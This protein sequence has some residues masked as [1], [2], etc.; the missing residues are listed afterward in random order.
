MYLIKIHFAIKWGPNPL[1]THFNVLLKHPLHW[2]V[3]LKRPWVLRAISPRPPASPQM[4]TELT[5]LWSKPKSPENFSASASQSH[6]FPRWSFSSPFW[7]R[8]HQ[9][10]LPNTDR[11]RVKSAC[12][13]LR[14]TVLKGHFYFVTE[15]RDW[16]GTLRIRSLAGEDRPPP[17]PKKP[18]R[19]KNKILCKSPWKEQAFKCI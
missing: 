1:G 18:T 8:G 15:K 13:C 5:L 3:T 9:A 12:P 14:T 7:S 10:A 19:K 6:L 2:S 11:G 17:S 4:P 16:A